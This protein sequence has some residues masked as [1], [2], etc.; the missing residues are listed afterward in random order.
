MITQSQRSIYL[1]SK[2]K[3]RPV[4]T[5]ILVPQETTPGPPPGI[6]I[7]EALELRETISKL[8]LELEMA[9]QD[10]AEKEDNI[11]KMSMYSIWYG[12]WDVSITCL[13]YSSYA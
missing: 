2:E 13:T 4:L 12:L 9:Q 10:V 6:T 8:E 11:R 3:Y 7:E 1:T 5:I